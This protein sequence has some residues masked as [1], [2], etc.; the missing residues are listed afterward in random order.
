MLTATGLTKQ[1]A[2]SSTKQT[3]TDLTK[4]TVTNVTKRTA[5]K[6]SKTVAAMTWTKADRRLIHILLPAG[7]HVQFIVCQFDR[8]SRVFRQLRCSS[9]LMEA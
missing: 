1:T 6:T 5:T 8:F 3:A 9:S 7:S 2:T 4:Q